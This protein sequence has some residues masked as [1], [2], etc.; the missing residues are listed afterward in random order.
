[1]PMT[2]RNPYRATL[3]RRRPSIVVPMLILAFFLLFGVVL[4]ICAVGF[5]QG[6]WLR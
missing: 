3:P 5:E 1:M 2:T 6:W 4:P